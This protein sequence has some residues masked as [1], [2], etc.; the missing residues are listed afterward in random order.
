MVKQK[1]TYIALSNVKLQLR[2]IPTAIF[3]VGVVVGGFRGLRQNLVHSQ[4]LNYHTGAINSLYPSLRGTGAVN[5]TSI[6]LGPMRKWTK[7]YGFLTI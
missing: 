7:P 4:I 5:H 3:G 6:I 2:T 1:N